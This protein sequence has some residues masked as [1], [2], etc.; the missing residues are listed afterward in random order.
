MPCQRKDYIKD[1]YYSDT[2]IFV[3]YNRCSN[4]VPCQRKDHIQFNL[5][6]KKGFLLF[7]KKQQYCDYIKG[8]VLVVNYF[9]VL[10][11]L[12]C[13][14]HFP[15]LLDVHK[16]RSLYYCCMVNENSAFSRICS[17]YYCPQIYLH[18]SP[19]SINILLAH[20]A[21]TVRH[22]EILRD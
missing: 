1:Q 6:F 12:P 9:E 4:C 18:I 19:C 10:I 21:R 22:C 11:V 13:Q 7:H 16:Q 14:F 2:S 5:L 15:N 17:S 3:D 20:L 8:Y